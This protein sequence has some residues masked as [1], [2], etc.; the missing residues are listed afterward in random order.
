VQPLFVIHFF[1]KRGKS[2][3]N[4]LKRAVF[5]KIDFLTLENLDKALSEGILIGV[6]STSHADLKMMLFQPLDIFPRG[7]LTPPVRVVD[8]ASGRVSLRQSHP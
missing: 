8:A 7:I 2:V 6:S 1:N 4:V 3:V 5:P